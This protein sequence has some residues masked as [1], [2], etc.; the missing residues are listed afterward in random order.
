MEEFLTEFENETKQSN[1]V[2]K[3]V[4]I[5]FLSIILLSVSFF[6]YP[7]TSTKI[8]G[9]LK[10]S[11]NISVVIFAQFLPLMMGAIFILKKKIAWFFLTG[12]SILFIIVFIHVVYKH[13]FFYST[14]VNFTNYIFS[15]SGFYRL[16]YFI[17]II[18]LFNK[19][20]LSYL[21]ISRNNI[22]VM[23]FIT[24][25]FTIFLFTTGI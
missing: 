24:L 10:N 18:L 23:I 7:F 6:Y 9:L 21:N 19:S 14:N 16:S 3:V 8:S 15:W 17:L 2:H 5:L 12:W 13:M 11:S 4:S 22:L 1:I 20:L 25:I